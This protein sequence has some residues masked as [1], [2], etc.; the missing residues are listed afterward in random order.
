MQNRA[1]VFRGNRALIV[2]RLNVGLSPNQL[3]RRAGVHG[4]QVRAAE[5]GDYVGPA[6]QRA[7][8]DALN[9]EDVLTLFPWERQ[10]EAQR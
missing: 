4:N 8:C 1:R 9:V 3:A 7:I 10:R 2:A 5:H 6:I